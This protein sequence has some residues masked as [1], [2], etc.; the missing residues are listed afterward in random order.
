MEQQ[1]EHG[2]YNFVSGLNTDLGRFARREIRAAESGYNIKP[3]MTDTKT[4]VMDEINDDDEADY[5]DMPPIEAVA[6]EYAR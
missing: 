3:A 1:M 6:T 4:A 2:A 5:L